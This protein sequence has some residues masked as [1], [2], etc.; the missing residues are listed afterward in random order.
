M[1]KRI[2]SISLL[3][4]LLAWGFE[5]TASAIVTFSVLTKLGVSPNG[6]T[7]NTAIQGSD[8]NIYGTTTSGGA[9]GDGT[10]YEL[11][12]GG[13]LNTLYSFTGASDGSAPAGPLVEGTDGNYYG[14]TSTG[15]ANQVGTFFRITPGPG[16]TLTTLHTFNGTTEGVAPSLLVLGTDGNFYGTSPFAGSSGTGAILQITTAGTV[17]ILHT[18]V[19]GTDGNQPNPNIVEG[20]DGAFYGST[21]GGG[22]TT[23]GTLFRVTTPTT[24]T[25][26]VSF[27]VIGNLASLS[28]QPLLTTLGNDGNLYG[29]IPGFPGSIFKM[30]NAGV[31]TTFYTFTDLDDGGN[32]SAFVQGSDGNFYGTSTHEGADGFGTFF[33]ISSTGTFQT[34]Y[35]FPSTV[36]GVGIQGMVEGTD[37]NYYATGTDGGTGFAGT[38]LQLTTADAATTIFSFT[39]PGN[40]P[41]AALVQALDG[42]LYG[43][44][45]FGGATNDGTIFQVTTT[46][47]FTTL[48]SFTFA[49][50]GSQPRAA[51]TVDPDTGVLYGSAST[52]GPA[53]SPGTGLGGTAVTF[54]PSSVNGAFVAKSQR[55]DADEVNVSGLNAVL[56]LLQAFES[57]MGTS[58]ISTDDPAVLQ[59]GLN[60][61]LAPPPPVIRGGNAVRAKAVAEPAASP[62][63]IFLGTASAAGANGLG[64]IVS[65]TPDGTI[66]DL[67]DFGDAGVNDGSGPE[68]AF[69]Q[70][71]ASDFYGTTGFGGTSHLGTV[72]KVTVDSMGNGT[73]SVIHN[74][75]GGTSDGASPGGNDLVVGTDGNIYGTTQA[76]G[77]NNGGVIFSMTPSGTIKVLHSF[78]SPSVVGFDGSEPHTGMIQAS[79]GNFY[80]TTMGGGTDGIGTVFSITPKGVLTILHS[81]SNTDGFQPQA[82]LIQANDG[83]LYGVTSGGGSGSGVI[84]SIDAGLPVPPGTTAQT[85]TFPA[86]ANQTF[87]SAPVTLSATASSGLAAT[88]AVSGPA[89]LSGSTLTLT[90]VGT[91]K[92]TASQSG[93]STF[94]A[95]TPVAVSFTVGKGTQTISFPAVAD[96]TFGEAAFTLPNPP[97]ATSH[98]A[99][100]LKVLSGPATISGTKVT[101]TGAGV[102]TLAANQPGSVNYTAAPQVTSS[103][104][105]NK[106][107]Q[108]IAAF[109]AIATQNDGE[110]AF[111]VVVPK[112]SSGLVVTLS[113]QSG[114]ATISGTKVTVNGVGT[115]VLA[116]DQAGNTN[117]NVA[118]E[119]TTSFTVNAAKQTIAPFAAIA[120]KTFGVAPFTITPP[121]ASSGLPVTVTVLSGPSSISGDTVTVTG[122][123]TVVLA[124]NQAGD[125][126]HAAAAQV[127]TSFVVKDGLQTITAFPKIATQTFGE[128]PFAITPPTASSG[129]TVSVTVKSGPATISG[130]TVTL[131]GAGT[132]VLAADQSGNSDYNPAKEVVTS[133]VVA[134]EAQTIAAFSSISSQTF[135]TAPFASTPPA[136]SSNLAVTVIVKSGPARITA[137]VVTLT[138]V[139][140]VVLEATQA[141]NTN[142]LAAT[143]V[144]TS[145][146]VT[147]GSQTIAAFVAIPTKIYGGPAFTITP[148]HASSGLPVT[149]TV[150]SG[151][152]TIRA[153]SVT[154][155][156]AGTVV[157][158]ANQVGNV[159]VTAAPQVTTSFTVNPDTQTIAAFKT[160]PAQVFG[161][162]PFAVAA[163]VAS[164]KLAVTLSVL[165]GP[166]S[167]TGTK[168]TLTGVGTVVLAADQAGNAN[169]E[170]A[171]EVTT[172]FVVAKEAQTI[173]AFAVIAAK[174][175]ASA[176]FTITPPL[177]SSGLP[178]T[179]TVVSGPATI[180]GDTVTLTGTTGTVVLGANQSGDTNFNAAKQVTTSIAVK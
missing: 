72:Y 140:T 19:A 76:G 116:A 49:T 14:T 71:D 67:Y 142:F 130:D 175:T 90:G 89:T 141:G 125:I 104:L 157:L 102:V 147:K 111:A 123:G 134:K 138:G 99:V 152:A 101:L 136:A 45:E 35:A 56:K 113:V 17:S 50:T 174:T 162:V 27:S 74:F 107:S 69:I 95:A 124:A 146:T 117:Y 96:Q 48:D 106:A 85:I 21:Q 154:L 4:S 80:G 15:G 59:N 83:K 178:V 52:G 79:D 103:I 30:T 87:G 160:I 161:V 172:S 139:G 57:P 143:A 33:K 171:A 120:A 39:E 51:L 40:N 22:P 112:A 66:T 36:G 135:G 23:F 158:A 118:P 100:T 144:T 8:G 91:V 25:P 109:A 46:G 54:D 159:D 150:V 24:V 177:A 5:G 94:K 145:F 166:A 156:G 129:L 92:V 168:L 29:C 133:F 3:L 70:A 44:T 115:V 164:S 180:S 11:T 165:S 149:V 176:P 131:T 43:T 31:L 167:L 86:I 81:F 7:P 110:P 47:S 169:F 13:T 6:F 12:T 42:N 153:T 34:L 137:G 121:K 98:L 173:K 2:L 16:G 61:I 18:F 65:I 119:I 78:Q 26:A 53:F 132:V 1:H 88:Y 179:V 108:T 127:T 20:S 75:A 114:P 155:T 38:I 128:A 105:V 126:N 32:P 73:Y 170:P 10:V 41:V 122:V 151:P 9:S 28:N 55:K 77:A 37:G 62:A 97:T 163:P 58:Q 68:S 148:P 63:L 84:F 93:N 64:T 60:L 82:A